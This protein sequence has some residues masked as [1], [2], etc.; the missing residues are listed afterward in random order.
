MN[1]NSI[2]FFYEKHNT[3]VS[4]CCER[5]KYHICLMKLIYYVLAN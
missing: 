4:K 3:D 5:I 2:I 1:V